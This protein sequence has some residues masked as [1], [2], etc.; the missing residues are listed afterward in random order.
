M[1]YQDHSQSRRNDCVPKSLPR[2]SMI[3]IWFVRVCGWHRAWNGFYKDLLGIVTTQEVRLLDWD[4]LYYIFLPMMSSCII[5]S[6]NAE[7]TDEDVVGTTSTRPMSLC[8]CTD[9]RLQEHSHLLKCFVHATSCPSGKL[10]IT[11]C[12]LWP[13]FVSFNVT[14]GERY[15][16]WHWGWHFLKE[17]PTPSNETTLKRLLLFL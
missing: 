15:A 6:H 3:I 4:Q 12:V 13:M 10:E 9:S 17:M 7:Y 1:T 2:N 8:H 11:G 5:T 16:D 14:S